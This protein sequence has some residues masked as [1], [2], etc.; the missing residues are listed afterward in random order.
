M[1]SWYYTIDYKPT[2]HLFI[3]SR[4]TTHAPSL[5]PRLHP[6]AFY[7]TYIHGAIKSLGVESGNEATMHLRFIIVGGTTIS[8]PDLDFNSENCSDYAS[9]R[10]YL[11]A[12]FP[13][14]Y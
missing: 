3:E 14:Q 4:E 11:Q 1:K 12:S 10:V 13:V 6:Q 8:E 7:R 2:T 9:L 5:V